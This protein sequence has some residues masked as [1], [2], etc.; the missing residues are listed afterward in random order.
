[1]L[2]LA[3][4]PFARETDLS[5][6]ASRPIESAQI[7]RALRQ[8]AAQLERLLGEAAQRLRLS[9]WFSVVQ[10]QLLDAAQACEADLMVLGSAFAPM[11]LSPSTQRRHSSRGSVL[12]LYDAS[13]ETERALTAAAALA[14]HQHAELRVLVV[15][16]DTKGCVARQARAQQW[17]ARAGGSAHFIR[18]LSADL[19]HLPRIVREQHA[20]YV[21]VPNNST[22]LQAAGLDLLLARAGCPLILSR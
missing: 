15:A 3:E 22:L 16:C 8:Q 4:L 11:R 13:P 1:M 14:A 21:V 18:I 20:D 9:W 17:L 19:E 12:A 6:A 5:T 7:K 10:G 2:R